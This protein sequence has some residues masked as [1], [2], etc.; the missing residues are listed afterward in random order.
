MIQWLSERLEFDFKD[1]WGSENSEGDIKK[2]YKNGHMMWTQPKEAP[3]V[4]R[5]QSLA[6]MC[7]KDNE[8]NDV[9]TFIPELYELAKVGGTIAQQERDAWLKQHPG[10]TPEDY[11]DQPF[12]NTLHKVENEKIREKTPFEL[13]VLNVVY[14]DEGVRKKAAAAAR[15]IE[16]HMTKEYLYRIKN[17]QF[18]PP[19]VAKFQIESDYLKNLDKIGLK[20]VRPRDVDLNL[21]NPGEKT[22]L[23]ERAMHYGAQRMALISTMLLAVGVFVA[24]GSIATGLFAALGV[25][26]AEWCGKEFGMFGAAE[27]VLRSLSHFSAQFRWGE[28]ISLKKTLKTA[29]LFTALAFA[30]YGVVTGA[31]IGIMSLPWWS[32]TGTG[33]S[34]VAMNV[35]QHGLAALVSGVAGV[36]TFMGGLESVVFF[37][38]F[39]IWHKQIDFTKEQ[40]LEIPSEEKHLLEK[41]AKLEQKYNKNQNRL[42]ILKKRSQDQAPDISANSSRTTNSLGELPEQVSNTPPQDLIDNHQEE[43][44]RIG[45]RL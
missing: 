21:P 23:L 1:L 26:L 27:S 17:N 12:F 9:G 16:A 11:R 3:P 38:G 14:N 44:R 18:L 31:W 36:T 2:F 22:P 25:V 33:F 7:L 34:A 39:G 8:N 4:L 40:C 30:T 13:S 35:M 29:V 20:A 43:R 28:K 32:T 42:D 6:F 24:S 5:K 19:Y 10:A 41:L 37:W 15:K 45:S